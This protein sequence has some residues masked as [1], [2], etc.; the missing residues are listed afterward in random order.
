MLLTGTPLGA[1]DAYRLGLVNAL[2]GEEP[3][4]AAA[5]RLAR[6]LAAGPPLAHEA[7]KRLVHE[8]VVLPLGDAITLEREVV[9]GL[10]ATGDAREGIAAFR[11]KRT[12]TFLG[13]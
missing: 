4:L 9:A 11:E 7:A 12:P 13:R 6:E 3:A 1:I 10:Y 2:S 5:E 8:G